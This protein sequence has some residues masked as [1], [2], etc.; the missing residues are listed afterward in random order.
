MHL[1][2]N[3]CAGITFWV[4][5]KGELIIKLKSIKFREDI[6]CYLFFYLFYSFL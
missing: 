6:F 4:K 2:D 1:Q 5:Y 3:K